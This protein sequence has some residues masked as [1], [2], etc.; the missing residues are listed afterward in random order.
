VPDPLSILRAPAV[1]LWPDADF[2]AQLRTRLE[3]A[4]SPSGAEMPDP[5]RP[6]RPDT[7]VLDGPR[8]AG[9][10]LR[11][12]P[13]L[14]VVDAPRAITWYATVL[15]AEPVGAPVIM[16]DGHIGHAEL[17]LGGARL[18][19]SE[20]FPE[21]GVEAPAPDRGVPVTLHLEVVDVDAVTDLAVSAGAVL[22]RA[23][24]DNPYGRTAV[25]RDPFG[26]RWMLNA[27][28]AGHEPDSDHDPDA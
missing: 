25:V 20:Q 3:R 27:T 14:A 6:T 4:L 8:P 28:L 22:D 5:A 12:T 15:G 26:H 2:T 9:A 7:T 13:Y 1:P 23:P 24:G 21:I 11:L 10:S 18:Y 17:D 19:L 16:P